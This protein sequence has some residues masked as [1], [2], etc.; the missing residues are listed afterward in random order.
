MLESYVGQEVA[1]NEMKV[2]KFSAFNH[3]GHKSLLKMTNLVTRLSQKKDK[4]EKLNNYSVIQI[5]QLN[6][7][8]L[9]IEI[10][11]TT[12]YNYVRKFNAVVTC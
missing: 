11:L 4:T 2:Y 5:P 9:K 1:D 7:R 10:M 3:V 6:R 8:E 12:N